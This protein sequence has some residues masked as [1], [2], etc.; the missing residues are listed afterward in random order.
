[1]G[2]CRPA[3][4]CL[5]TVLDLASMTFRVPLAC[6]T[7]YAPPGVQPVTLTGE[8]QAKLLDCSYRQQQGQRRRHSHLAHCLRQM[9]GL[10]PNV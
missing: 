9:M 5:V 2:N 3:P 4:H 1:M 6:M 8:G 10:Q 7:M